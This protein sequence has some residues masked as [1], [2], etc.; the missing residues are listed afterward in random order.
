[1]FEFVIEFLCEYLDLTLLT[2]ESSFYW[3]TINK[4]AFKASIAFF[5]RVMFSLETGMFCHFAEMIVVIK[6][7]FFVKEMFGKKH[8]I[9]QEMWI[10]SWE[11]NGKIVRS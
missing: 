6:V 5:V 9:S 1:M 3:E 8:V 10:V 11:K 7:V 4:I 2:S